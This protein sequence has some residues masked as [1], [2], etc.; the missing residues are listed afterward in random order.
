[1]V[2]EID[3]VS[4][5]IKVKGRVPLGE[6]IKQINRMFPDFEYEKWT[7]IEEIVYYSSPNQY[8][9]IG[10]PYWGGGTQ[11]QPLSGQPLGMPPSITFGTGDT[12]FCGGQTYT[13]D[14][15]ENKTIG[16]LA[17]EKD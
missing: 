2:L 4:K 13:L 14:Q 17:S 10:Q 1:M 6:L 9:N 11:I 5:T 7:L 8:P 3:T 16:E 12:F 15:C